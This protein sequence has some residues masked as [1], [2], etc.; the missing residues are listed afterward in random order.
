MQRILEGLPSVE[1]QMDDIIVSGAN[2]AEHDERLEAVLIRLQE[3]KVT[4]NGEKC[5]SSKATVKCLG[6]LVSKDGIRADPS[7]VSAVKH[8]AEP[9]DIH[10]L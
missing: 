6:Q 5:E 9:T 3:A 4:F 2:Q 1:C 7:K 10:E 8:M